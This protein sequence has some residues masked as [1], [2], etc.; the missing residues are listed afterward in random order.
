METNN[1]KAVV[2]CIREMGIALGKKIED[3]FRNGECDHLTLEQMAEYTASIMPPQEEVTSTEA[4]KILRISLS[5][6]Y[7][8]IDAGLI[9]P[10]RKLRGSKARLYS[11]DALKED[12]VKFNAMNR[13]E[14]GLLIRIGQ[15]KKVR[16]PRKKSNKTNK[17]DKRTDSIQ[18]N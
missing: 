16:K 7:Q 17:N 10:P 5:R 14:R 8:L 1:N 4:A 6:F 3:M 9:T 11:V 2:G 15:A 12:M 18:N 13:H